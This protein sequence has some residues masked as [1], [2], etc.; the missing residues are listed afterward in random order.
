[1]TNT[2]RES[3]Q[4]RSQI[5]VLIRDLIALADALELSQN[6][7]RQFGLEFPI[8]VTAEDAAAGEPMQVNRASFLF[9]VRASVVGHLLETRRVQFGREID[10]LG[11]RHE[12]QMVVAHE[13]AA[14]SARSA[15]SDQFAVLLKLCI[16]PV[17]ENGYFCDDSAMSF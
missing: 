13:V 9:L 8:T 17:V 5:G 2:G 12:K 16:D 1:L 10:Q 4:G 7:F 14:G 11:R 3:R 15:L 6:G